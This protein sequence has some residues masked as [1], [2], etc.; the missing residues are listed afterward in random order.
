MPII[1]SKCV[2]CHNKD[3]FPVRLTRDLSSAGGSGE[4]GCF[5]HSYENLLA[6][7][8]QPEQWK[9]IHPGRAR[10]SPLIRHIFGRNTA[11]PWDNAASKK[12]PL[13]MPPADSPPLTEDEKLTFVEWID[14]GALWDGIP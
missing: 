12:A 3:G 4:K 14:M 6:P 10:T 1:T 11:R 13:L 2:Q 5:N 7:G 8:K 9:Y